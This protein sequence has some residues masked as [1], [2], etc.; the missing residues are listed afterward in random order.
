[1][2]VVAVKAISFSE[3]DRVFFTTRHYLTLPYP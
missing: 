3:L 1:M 2:S